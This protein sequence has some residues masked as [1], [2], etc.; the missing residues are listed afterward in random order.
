M[1]QHSL[2]STIV[3]LMMVLILLSSGLACFAIV[4]LSYSLGDAKAIN[5]S[6]SLRMQSYRLLFYANAGSDK[7]Q[8]S[9][10]DFEQTLHSKELQQLIDWSSTKA[11]GDQ[12]GLVIDKWQKM[13]HFAANEDSRKYSQSLRNFV[14][15]IDLLVLEMEHHAEFKLKVLAI[16]Q[17]VGLGMM[18]L[19]A[20]LAVRY[21]R[22]KVVRPLQGM[23]EAANAI[24]KGQFNVPMPQSDFIELSSLGQA[25]SSTATELSAL[26][27][28]LER[29]VVDKTLAL[30]RANNELGFLYD[31][32]WMLHTHKFDSQAIEQALFQLKGYEDFI[33]VSLTIDE[34]DH[35]ISLGDDTNANQQPNYDFSLDYEGVQLGYL[36]ATSEHQPNSAL[37]TNF[38]MMLARTLILKRLDDKQQQLA[39]LEERGT[40]ARELHDS[41]GQLL[42]FLKIQI[43]LLS[44]SLKKEVHSDKIDMQLQE[45]NEGINTAYAQLR[46]LLSTF[47]LT[48]SDPHLGNAIKDMIEQLRTQTEVSIQL[49]YQLKSHQ[50]NANQHIHIIQITREAVLNAIKHSGAKH[51]NVTA[52]LMAKQ[53]NISIDDDGI[54]IAHV[55]ERD[56]HFG[57]GIM[58]ERAAKLIGVVEFTTNTSGGTC[59]SLRFPSR[60]FA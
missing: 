36:R 33:A 8:S 48:I 26:Y 30:S 50:I 23:M 51:I 4:S 29:Q 40:I 49:D 58:Q 11:L 10:D 32:L 25:L 37:L 57:L 59:V 20:L 1:K 9:I 44:K 27:Q 41:L 24:S 55:R 7:V 47:R 42:A 5:A 35:V 16:S 2:T 17:V 22:K 31:T 18:L 53:V 52:R 34:G 46:E 54:G 15:S 21:T 60:E 45:I 13:K 14:D 43:S 39:L 3:N 38:A 28:D 6:G 12:Y 56:H 19:L